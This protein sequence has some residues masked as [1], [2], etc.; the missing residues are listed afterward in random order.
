M[1]PRKPK[2]IDP[3]KIASGDDFRLWRE[4]RGYSIR[5]LAAALGVFR[6]SIERWQ[7]GEP[8]PPRVVLL[9]LQALDT[10]QHEIEA[11]A[12]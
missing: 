5:A 11:V 4:Q 12:R 8:V 6:T 7:K 9:A 1:P 10:A 2:P 3:L